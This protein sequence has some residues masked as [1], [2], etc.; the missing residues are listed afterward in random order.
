MTT[1]CTPVIQISRG[2]RGA[3]D[4]RRLLFQAENVDVD[5]RLSPTGDIWTIIGQVLSGDGRLLPPIMVQLLNDGTAVKKAMTNYI[6]EF[7]FAE[8]EPSTFVLE[9]DLPDGRML[10]GLEVG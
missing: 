1:I 8:V 4:S 5:L 6:G 7:T 2:F 9:V 10:C 3:C